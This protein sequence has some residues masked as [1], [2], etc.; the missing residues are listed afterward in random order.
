MQAA[1][2]AMKALYQE[3]GIAFTYGELA[4]DP[5]DHQKLAEIIDSFGPMPCR[6]LSL[7]TERMAMLIEDAM[8]GNLN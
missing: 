7:T 4:A 5:Q 2:S 1:L 6:M 3:F 8:I